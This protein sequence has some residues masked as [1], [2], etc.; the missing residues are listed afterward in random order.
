MDDSGELKRV[1]QLFITDITV[2]AKKTF[3]VKSY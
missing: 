3:K 2:I 1:Y